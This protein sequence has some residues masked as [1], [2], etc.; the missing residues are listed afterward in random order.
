MAERR[1]ALSSLGRPHFF[2]TTMAS[3]PFQPRAR[4]GLLLSV[5]MLALGACAAIPNTGPKPQ[6]ASITSFETERSF[7]APASDWVSDR[8]W[9]AY[10]DAQ[11]SKLIDEALAQSPTL[12]EA[13]AR[14]RS[15][16][17]QVGESR[18][19]LFPHAS[20]NGQVSEV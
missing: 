14:M 8:W 12:A 15:A 2:E 17:A 16:D 3:L 7:S 11:L 13:E 5:A 20:F 19:A 6:T 1:S 4:A 10:G 18:S 9:D